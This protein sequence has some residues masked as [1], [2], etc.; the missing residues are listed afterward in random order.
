MQGT[1]LTA[2]GDRETEDRIDKNQFFDN[3]KRV[4]EH[5]NGSSQT[6]GG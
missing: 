1:G 6:L 4:K 3:N 2:G 5:S